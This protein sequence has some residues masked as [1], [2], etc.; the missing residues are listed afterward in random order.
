MAWAQNLAKVMASETELAW[1]M[2]MAIAW[3][4]AKGAQSGS[5]KVHAKGVQSEL[6]SDMLTVL[7]LGT[8]TGAASLKSETRQMHR[9][10]QIRRYIRPRP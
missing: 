8:Q 5:S 1:V 7:G 10:T 2:A 4:L 9:R 3:E 6:S